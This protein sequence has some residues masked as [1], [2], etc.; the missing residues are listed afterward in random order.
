VL[1]S[2]HE[3]IFCAHNEV[4]HLVATFCRTDIHILDLL[5]IGRVGVRGLANRVLVIY[6]RVHGLILL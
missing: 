6:I 4:S 2:G 5:V 1:F 3:I